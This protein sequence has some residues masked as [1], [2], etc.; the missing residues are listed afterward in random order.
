MKAKNADS[1][2]R[3]LGGGVLTP[4]FTRGLSLYKSFIFSIP[5]F[6]PQSHDSGYKD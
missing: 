3:L 2:A 6:F 1:G 5:Q 4:L